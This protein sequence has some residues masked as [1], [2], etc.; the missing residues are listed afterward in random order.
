MKIPPS[1]P[2]TCTRGVKIANSFELD[3]VIV[4]QNG[5]PSPAWKTP[6]FHE[7]GILAG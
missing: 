3:A 6:N 4:A 5:H 1:E 7:V 2:F